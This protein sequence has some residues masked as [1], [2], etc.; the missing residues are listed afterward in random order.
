M[1]S[2][3]AGIVFT[4]MCSL[5]ACDKIPSETSSI[6]ASSQETMPDPQAFL[7]RLYAHYSG[8][9]ADI[10]FSPTGA[11]APQWFDREMVG[12]M[13]EDA[14]LASGE[15]GAL[16][17]DPICD[18]QD[19]GTLSANIKIE[20]VT[21]TTARASVI[22]TETGATYSPETR[23]PRTFTYDLVMEDGDWRIH[24]IGT[25]DMP[26]LHDWLARSNAEAS[27]R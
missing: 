13:A 10:S 24:D 27:S 25:K 1:K 4:V 3:H 17:G 14:R 9:T 11:Q 22:I 18:C 2:I 23:Q 15:V 16:D 5:S 19:F 20:Q 12:L 8:N 6:V 7:T 26:S 21:A